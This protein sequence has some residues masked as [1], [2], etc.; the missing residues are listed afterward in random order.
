MMSRTPETQSSGGLEE[1]DRRLRELGVVTG[2]LM[3]D[4]GGIVSILAGRVALA[5][6]EA[7]LGR[8]PTDEL[9]RIQADTDELRRMVLEI[10]DELRGVHPSPEVTFPVTDT[11]EE[12]VDR[13][14]IGA[15]SV[16]TTLESSLPRD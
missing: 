5:R 8:T 7:T 4:L 1:Q 2:E 11:L 9:A 14:L 10:L 12:T 3:L 13:W 15:P 6:E 16:N